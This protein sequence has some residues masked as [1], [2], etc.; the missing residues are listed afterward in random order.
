MIVDSSVLIPLSRIG[1]LSLLKKYFKTVIITDEVYRETVKEPINKFGV[2]GIEQACGNWILIHKYKNNKAVKRIVELECIAPADA[3]LILL[4]EELHDSLLSNDYILIKTARARGVECWWLTTFILKIIAHG[5]VSKSEGK[6]IL[7]ELIEN[8]MRLSPQ[9][10]AV[11]TRRID[12][13]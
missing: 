1:R 4:A 2:S 6:Q 10:Y 7:L 13:I 3:S 8:G 12:D 9:V 5:T 11:V